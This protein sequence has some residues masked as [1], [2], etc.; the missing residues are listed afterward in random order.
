MT[1]RVKGTE[2]QL[3]GGEVTIHIICVTSFMNGPSAVEGIWIGKVYLQVFLTRV[4]FELSLLTFKLFNSRLAIVSA[5]INQLTS[6][7][8]KLGL[9]YQPESIQLSI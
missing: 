7:L 8:G 3:Y 4:K 5:T 6:L 2:P 1:A 9:G